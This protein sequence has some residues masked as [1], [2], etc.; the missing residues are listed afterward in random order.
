M[1]T[2]GFHPDSLA[3]VDDLLTDYYNFTRCVKPDG[4]AYGTKGQCKSG[5]PQEETED[6]KRNKK[7][8]QIGVPIPEGESAED[9]LQRLLPKG[10]VVHRPAQSA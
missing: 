1:N 6:K 3:A 9:V 8:A 7:V 2:P 5:S 4:T 10:A